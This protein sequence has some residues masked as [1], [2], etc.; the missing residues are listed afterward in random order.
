M[1]QHIYS[2]FFSGKFKAIR[3]ESNNWDK[4]HLRISN[5]EIYFEFDYYSPWYF[6]PD[7]GSDFGV[8][9]VHSK[10]NLNLRIMKYEFRGKNIFLRLEKR[11]I[12][13]IRSIL[14]QS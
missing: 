4:F 7:V 8:K 11:L 5:C 14:D 3:R 6:N 13:N 2:F 1:I 10:Q 12:Y 9:C